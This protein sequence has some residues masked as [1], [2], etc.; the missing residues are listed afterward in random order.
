MADPREWI[1][2]GLG[3]VLWDCFGQ[4]R[5]PGG[6]PANVAFHAAQLGHAGTVC[7]RVGADPLGA[8]LTAYIAGHGLDTGYIQQDPA[9]PTGTVTV[10]ANRPDH[11][12]YLIHQDV[13]WDHIEFTARV[14]DLMRRAS[15]VCFGSLAQRS[16]GSRAAIRRCL[17]AAA[18]A[19]R[20]F[21]V[22]LRQSW[23]DRQCIEASL[24]LSSVAKLNLDEVAVLSGLLGLPP[25]PV[26]FARGML[27]RF[28]L[29]LVCITRAERGCLLAAASGQ[30]VD[31]AGVPVKVVDAVGS[32]DAFSAAL[33][34][35]HLRGWPLERTAAF[36]NAVGS[37]VAGRAGAMPAL[38]EEYA[39]LAAR[40]GA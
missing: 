4:V 30:V 33:I 1:V 5:R 32:G 9:H 22:N 40:F 17:G 19:L 36:A 31:A 21:D 16:A 2:V 26:A 10:D 37:L 11:P 34:S 12:T 27:S 25:E 18:G 28:G 15:A 29:G 8:E 38:P 35:A 24:G 20:V 6:A 13:A 7:S 23:Y 14:R 39:D 3:E